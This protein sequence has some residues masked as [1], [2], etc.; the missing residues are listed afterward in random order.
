PCSSTTPPSVGDNAL[1]EGQHDHG[2]GGRPFDDGAAFGYKVF[3]VTYG[4]SLELFG[5]K[6]VAPENRT[7]PKVADAACAVPPSGAQSDP[8]A[9]AALSGESWARLSG[10]V[11]AQSSSIALDRAVDWEQGDRLVVTSTDWYASHSE[12]VTI[13]GIESGTAAFALSVP[14]NFD[15][16]G[17]LYDVA[18]S[19]PDPPSANQ[20]IETRAAVGLLSRDIRVYSLGDT[21]DQPFP[22]AADCG[23]QGDTSGNATT[24]P[25]CYFGGHVIAR[26]GFRRFQ[27]QGVEFSELGQGG[28]L[29][30]YPVHFHMVKSTAYTNAF[31]KDSSIDNSMNRFVTIHAT[32]NVTVARNVGFRSVGHGFYVE[33][34]SEIDNLLCHNLAVSVQGSLM[35]YFQ[36]QDPD[37]PTYRFSPPILPS[38]SSNS[39][40]SGPPY[41]SDSYF[42]VGFWL[43]NTWNEV[44]GNQVV[45]VGGFGSCYWLLGSGVSGPSQDLHWSN[46]TT[47]PAGYADYNLASTQ[48]APLKRF[49]GN[50]CST[51][52]YALQTTT[53]VDPPSFS[54]AQYGY[55]PAVN[56][57]AITQDMLPLVG[58]D[59]L[60]LL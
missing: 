26:Q 58:G 53:Q 57:Y 55:T 54:A 45:G 36:A 59:Y 34:G 3:A 39:P 40:S 12:D 11:A 32:H 30:H 42:P 50:G 7:D 31:L 20:Q 10:D 37:S 24:P 43:M 5:A 14:L 51:S 19:I 17:T 27:M 1:F 52:Q 25:N 49:R 38:V 44:V 13:A 9:W 21:Y 29:A 28:R 16:S 35:E 18:D 33:D 46:S 2:G 22:S 56:P 15:H 4:G 8:A 23:Y 48:Q 41:G 47:T 6:G 60:P